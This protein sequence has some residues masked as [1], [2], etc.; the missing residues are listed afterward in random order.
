MDAPG[1]DMRPGPAELR[2]VLEL[3]CP[4]G[5]VSQAPGPLGSKRFPQ[6]LRSLNRMPPAR[7]GDTFQPACAPCA[8]DRARWSE[9]TKIGLLP[10]L[11][12]MN[13]LPPKD[14]TEIV[15]Q[16]YRLE[17]QVTT[18]NMIDIAW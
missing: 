4:A 15:R 3:S 9:P 18:G 10:R 13:P 7:A 8:S 17:R 1:S 6:F 2:T 16:V 12:E 14:R 5:A 11:G